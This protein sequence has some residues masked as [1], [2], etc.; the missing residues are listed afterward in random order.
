MAI[1]ER[2]ATGR[3]GAAGAPGARARP[4]PGGRGSRRKRLRR[5]LVLLLM[6]PGLVYF[7]VFQYGALAGNVIAFKDY[8]PFDGLWA[9][10]WVGL[11]DFHAILTDPA[12]WHAVVNTLWIALLQL[13][14]FF[15]VPIALAML[16]GCA[17]LRLH[18]EDGH[19]DGG[20]RPAG[21][22]GL[23]RRPHPAPRGRVRGGQV[24][25][26]VAVSVR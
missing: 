21:R 1:T 4:G 13:V 26:P 17:R 6:A 25:G 12:F 22:H 3:K 14:F 15:P 2:D 7:L 8:V 18:D 9:S 24:R 19:H 23:R 5:D 16:H 10:Q 11:T 20:Q